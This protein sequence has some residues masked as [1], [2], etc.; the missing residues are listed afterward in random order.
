MPKIAKYSTFQQIY[1][2]ERLSTRCGFPFEWLRLKKP[3]SLDFYLPKQNIAIECQGIQHYKAIERFGGEEE[4]VKIKNRDFIKKELC[5]KQGIA[6]VYYSKSDIL[7]KEGLTDNIAFNERT[8]MD[9]I[10]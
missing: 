9:L 10:N 7:L 4:L 3:L 8:L 6:L 1:E 2:G 5:E